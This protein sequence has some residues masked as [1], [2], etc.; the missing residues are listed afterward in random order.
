MFLISVILFPQMPLLGCI[1]PG[2]TLCKCNCGLFYF[3]WRSSFGVARMAIA[4]LQTVK[5][6]CLVSYNIISSQYYYII[7]RESIIIFYSLAFCHTRSTYMRYQ[8]ISEERKSIFENKKLIDWPGIR[9]QV[10]AEWKKDRYNM[11][12]NSNIW[13]AYSVKMARLTGRSNIKQ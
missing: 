12:K 4:R 9:S 13:V 6:W 8:A 1:Y 5:C 7:E 10:N 2:Y 3:L 11:C